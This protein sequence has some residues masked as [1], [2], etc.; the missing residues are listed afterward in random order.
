MKWLLKIHLTQ[1]GSAHYELDPVKG[2]EQSGRQEEEHT[3][4]TFKL[5]ETHL[6]ICLKICKPVS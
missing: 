3:S 1:L 2:M 5:T 4:G 6:K